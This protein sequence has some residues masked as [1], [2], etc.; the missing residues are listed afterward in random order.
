MGATLGGRFATVGHEVV[1]G[2]RR[3]GQPDELLPA[4]AVAWSEVVLLCVP[5][6]AVIP[7]LVEG[8]NAAGKVVVDATNPIAPTFDGLAPISEGSNAERLD[9]MIPGSYVVKAFN[10]FGVE[11]MADPTF[12]GGPATLLVAGDD[13]QAKKLVLALGS[14]IGLEPMDAGPLRQ[15][16]WLEALAWLWISMA[17]QFGAGRNIAFRVL[18][19]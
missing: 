5:G 9:H 3:P 8:W 7:E 16:R 17:V 15:A 4:D 10:T 12:P 2:V 19:R 11:V 14:Q 1:F 6:H 13:P 18:R